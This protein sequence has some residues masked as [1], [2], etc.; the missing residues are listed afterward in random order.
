MA[1]D[2]ALTIISS[3]SSLDTAKIKVRH[4]LHVAFTSPTNTSV[5]V[6]SNPSRWQCL[7]AA[8][9]IGFHDKLVCHDANFSRPPL[10]H[11]QVQRTT[12]HA[13]VVAIFALVA[14]TRHDS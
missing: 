12:G 3:L 4:S 2:N 10:R 8:A 1:V 7:G 13:E 5:Y 6:C 9:F 14:V 11:L